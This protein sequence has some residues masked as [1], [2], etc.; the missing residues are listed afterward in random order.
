MAV[1][2]PQAQF[3]G[4]DLSPV[5]VAQGQALIQALGLD[6]ITLHVRS[7]LEVDGTLGRF[8]YVLAHGVYS[9]VPDEVQEKMLA[10]CA[11]QLSAEG[12]AYVS[13][14][15][16]PGWHMRAMVR[17]LMRYHAM[18]FE[19][20][21]QRVRQARAI[22]DFLARSVPTQDSAY[23]LLLKG[24]LE[25]LR[26]APDY[27]I[28]HEHLEDI[29]QP[30]YFH[31]FVARA[32]R[33][34]LQYLAEAD[35]SSMLDSRLTPEVAGTLRQISSDQVQQEQFMDFL[36]NRTFRQT[37]LVRGDRALQRQ[38]RPEQVCNLWVSGQLA[39]THLRPDLR[40]D[41]EECFGA[42][43]GGQL[44]TCQR[45]TKA[46]VIVLARHWPAA[47]AFDDL[48]QAALDL[49]G[50][51][52]HTAAQADGPAGG[53]APALTPREVLASDVL[54]CHLA[55][56]LALHGGPSPF[57]P[58]AGERPRA[59]AL[60]R[61]QAAHG[62]PYLTTLQH[63]PIGYDA[64]MGR[65]LQLLDGSRDRATLGRDAA[66]HLQSGSL[67]ALIGAVAHAGLLQA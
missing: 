39:P 55:G 36:H 49:A 64:P 35:F 16:L 23:G 59:S 38:I 62:M 42:P 24:E 1:A 3:V 61:W 44:K 48:L 15:T 65:L 21:G 4:I 8:D 12:V 28:L 25:N 40:G 58:A 66:A 14:N 5:Q 51:D 37:L 27:Y 32:Q 7:I 9:W 19:D 17:D 47:L 50:L 45:V 13:Y 52:A 60:A 54:Q 43:G 29:N 2:L 57:V 18:Q 41:G 22:L 63:T 11:S 56:L 34:G 10:I 46:A 6:N 31:D 53:Q 26:A 67:D 20:P 33:H 30:I